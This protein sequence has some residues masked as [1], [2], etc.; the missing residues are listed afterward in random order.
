MHIDDVL[1]DL[2]VLLVTLGGMT[3]STDHSVNMPYT[4]V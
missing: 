2:V 4:V 3:L 1:K